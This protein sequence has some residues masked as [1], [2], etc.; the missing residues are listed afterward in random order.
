MIDQ[1]GHQ[2]PGV[3]HLRKT[4][5]PDVD[6][7]SAGQAGQVDLPEGK[8]DRCNTDRCPADPVE[9]DIPR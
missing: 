6:K 3:L 4:G 5:T 2:R 8:P 1:T 7:V 9:G